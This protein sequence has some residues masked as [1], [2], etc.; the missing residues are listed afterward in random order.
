MKRTTVAFLVIAATYSIAGAQLTD[1]E[2]LAH[3]LADKNTRAKT[4]AEIVASGDSA[5]P[6][7]LDLAETPPTDVDKYELAVGL[8]EAFGQ[9][10]TPRAIPFLLKNLGLN[11]QNRV[12]VWLKTPEIIE[13]TLPAVAALERIG[14]AA[15]KALISAY[16]EPMLA[17]DRPA[18]VFV[19]TRI[20][21]AHPGSVP[22]ARG[23]LQAVS[24]ELRLEARWAGE[25]LQFLD[26]RK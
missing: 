9:L 13:Q 17:E 12:N 22:E 5:V 24:V 18:A 1:K 25:G 3:D 8:A 19:V 14:P 15:A 4:V 7:L 16:W 2:L 21:E 11:P 6:F 20:I 10:R 23:F 26:Q